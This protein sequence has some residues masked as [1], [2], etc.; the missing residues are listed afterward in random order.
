MN[1]KFVKFILFIFKKI[2]KLTERVAIP[3]KSYHEK[4][5]NHIAHIHHSCD[6]RGSYEL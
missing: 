2:D 3:T 5:Y 1:G 4:N 6:M